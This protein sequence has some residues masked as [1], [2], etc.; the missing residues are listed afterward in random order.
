M[1]ARIGEVEKEVVVAGA[2]GEVE[3]GVA[4]AAWI[5]VVVDVVITS[6]IV[7]VVIR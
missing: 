2:K 3:V 7:W 4:V 6:A 1:G 5:N